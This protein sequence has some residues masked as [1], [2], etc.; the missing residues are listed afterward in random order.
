M[1]SKVFFPEESFSNA[2]S[3]CPFVPHSLHFFLKG[4]SFVLRTTSEKL[5]SEKESKCFCD[6]L[7]HTFSP[8]SNCP[9][10]VQKSRGTQGMVDRALLEGIHSRK[11]GLPPWCHAGVTRQWGHSHV[12]SL[13]TC[14]GMNHPCRPH[15]ALHSSDSCGPAG[16][17][18]KHSNPAPLGEHSFSPSTDSLGWQVSWEIPASASGCSS[19]T[20]LEYP[21]FAST[22]MEREGIML[23]EISWER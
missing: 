23:S 6:T 21:Q 5:A 14:Q 11:H 8:W 7:K 17:S 22:W 1:A 13:A 18:W 19:W 12:S 15:S 2:C 4:M 9:I 10:T 20:Q 3:A 16:A